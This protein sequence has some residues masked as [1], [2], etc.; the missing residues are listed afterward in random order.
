MKKFLVWISILVALL[1]VIYQERYNIA[2]KYASLFIIDTATKG[3]DAILIL[4][5]NIETRVVKAI[6]LQQKGYAEQIWTTSPYESKTKYPHILKSQNALLASILT[7][8]KI[9]KLYIVPSRNKGATSTFDEAYDLASY[10]QDNLIKRIIIV[11][12]GYHTARTKIAFDKVFKKMNIS[13][14]LEYAPSFSNT[15]DVNNWYKYENSLLRLLV[16]EPIGLLFYY[17]SEGN[18][19]LYI[20][21]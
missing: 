10:L 21:M 11:T 19:N 7:Y 3:A 15:F 20:N 17:F 6:E 16:L 8:E 9:D 13:T 1:V 4:A 18:S 5:G 2:S 12:D 14:K